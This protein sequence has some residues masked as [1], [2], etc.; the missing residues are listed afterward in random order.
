MM[1]MVVA[2]LFDKMIRTTNSFVYISCFFL[3]FFA[4]IAIILDN[5][6]KDYNYFNNLI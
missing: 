1:M 4:I 3:F 2:I 5:S 6:G